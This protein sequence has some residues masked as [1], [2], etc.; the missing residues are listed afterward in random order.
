[1]RPSLIWM[2]RDLALSWRAAA[3]EEAALSQ[4]SKAVALADR[5]V[6]LYRELVQ[7][8]PSMIQFAVELQAATQAGVQ[9]AR[10]SGDEAGARRRELAADDFWQKH[11]DA[12][13][14]AK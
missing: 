7:A 6:D 13:P 11:P 9:M 10:S 2:K 4:W 12:K 14:K 3:L 1:L 5:S 8:N